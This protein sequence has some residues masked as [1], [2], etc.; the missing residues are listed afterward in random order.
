MP[1]STSDHYVRPRSRESISQAASKCPQLA[2]ATL[3]YDFNIVDFIERTLVKKL[4]QGIFDI[5]L[6]EKNSE[7]QD[8]A[9]V[10]H[11]PL[12][13]HVSKKIWTAARNNEP[14]AR[15]VLA[16]E[17]GHLYLH[18]HFDLAYSI[19]REYQIRFAEDINSAEWQANEFAHYFLVPDNVVK[20]F[21][22]SEDIAAI[23]EV[24]DRV[25]EKRYYEHN[26]PQLPKCSP[27]GG[28][29]PHCFRYAVYRVKSGAV[30]LV[31][32]NESPIHKDLRF[33]DS[34][35]GQLNA[36]QVESIEPVVK[37]PMSEVQYV[38]DACSRCANFTLVRNGTCLKC[39]TCGSTT[40]CS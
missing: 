39:D 4:P 10:G 8:E 9:Y 30:C 2:G 6:F 11:K 27:N 15:Y 34:G 38:G 25:A 5:V 12:R 26:R 31:C 1:E 22:K 14:Y 19:G 36:S 40:G 33:R 18:D 23:C 20:I 17:I 16:H 35:G 21:T 37:Q 3:A 32:R 24:E 29:C 7:C 28:R 13:L